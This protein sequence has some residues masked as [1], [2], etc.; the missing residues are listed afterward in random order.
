MYIMTF[1]CR[2]EWLKDI[3]MILW[4]QLI[5]Q[6]HYIKSLPS[7]L[8]LPQLPT[9]NKQTHTVFFRAAR[10]YN[11]YKILPFLRCFCFY[12]VLVEH[13]F[14]TAV[15]LVLATTA[16]SHFHKCDNKKYSRIYVNLLV[17]PVL[18]VTRVWTFLIRYY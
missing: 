10:Y 7:P 8:S 2:G 17:L 9:K 5:R 15:L 11:H 3:Y 12:F 18:S 13:C 14:Y 6:D 4:N 16:C 1:Y